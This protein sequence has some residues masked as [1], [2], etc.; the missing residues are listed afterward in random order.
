MATL[1]LP[2]G[3][4]GYRDILQHVIKTGTRRAP[5]GMRTVDA[6]VTTLRLLSP[7]DALP[8]D[9][10]RG[11]SERIAAV[12]AVQLL[13]GFADAKLMAFASPNFSRYAEPDGEFYGAYGRRIDGQL[14]WAVDK[15]MMDRETRQAVITLWDPSLDNVPGKRDYPCT[16]ALQLAVVHDR[17]ELHVLM[18][19]NDAWL[20]I[21]YDMFQFTQ[22]QLAVAR[23]MRLEPG[24]YSHT[25]WSLHIYEQNIEDAD[26]VRYPDGP[27]RTQLP[28]GIGRDHIDGIATIKQRAH[29]IA[30][31]NLADMTPSEEWYRE[32]LAPFVG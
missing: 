3:R 8:V 26:A 31:S 29:L 19:S 1:E 4:E 5:R 30:Y 9:V 24:P 10:G 13:G 25:A 7:Y 23:A 32:H 15:M 6:G 18:R 12:E 11:V 27:P 17:L 2:S 21:P 28:H 14:L 16:V 22:L 20:G